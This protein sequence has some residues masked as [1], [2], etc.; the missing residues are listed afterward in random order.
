MTKVFPG[1]RKKQAP[2]NSVKSLADDVEFTLKYKGFYKPTIEQIRAC[3]E[4]V[5][6]EH[7]MWGKGYDPNPMIKEVQRELSKRGGKI[8]GEQSHN[9]AE[10][11]KEFARANDP[12]MWLPLGNA[13]PVQ[14]LLV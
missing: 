9:K 1:N 13:K 2:S 7:L 11:K 8:S 6:K 3:I 12:Q 10:H 4:L 5:M 14:T